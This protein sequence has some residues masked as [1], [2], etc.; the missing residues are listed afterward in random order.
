MNNTPGSQRLRIL[1]EGKSHTSSLRGKQKRQ[2]KVA[3]KNNRLKAGHIT[4][5]LFSRIRTI[6][7][8]KGHKL[9]HLLCYSDYVLRI[10]PRKP[11]S[12]PTQILINA[13]RWLKCAHTK[14]KSIMKPN[15]L[16]TNDKTPSAG[17]EILEKW[18]EVEI[19][20]GDRLIT[21]AELKR[22][23]KDKDAVLCQAIDK[24]DKAI[25]GAAKKL[26]VIAT[27]TAGYDNV[28]IVEATRRG[29]YVTYSPVESG[30]TETT[31]DFT[32]A[33]LMAL[34]RRIPEAHKLVT[35]GKW[36]GWSPTL[37]MGVEIRRKVLGIVGLGRI[38]NTIARTAKCFD[39]KVIYFDIMRQTPE[40]EKELGITYQPI[41]ALLKQSDFVCLH[42]PLLKETLQ[43]ISEDRLKMMK[44]TAFLINASRGPVVDEKALIKA[45]REKWIAGAALDVYE[46]EPAE[47]TNPLLK[48]DNTILT[49][50]IG[51][52]AKETRER[53]AKCTA[54]Y[55][56]E[57]LKGE[58]PIYLANPEVMKVRPLSEVKMI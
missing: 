2:S 40:R 45:L 27:A 22:R 26:K 43:L 33:L 56:I 49:P 38:G 24:F 9:R 25:V 21:R 31:A 53:M 10:F 17:I 51:G 32:W 39:M 28:D 58:K 47:K 1:T 15:V 54:R 3:V 48:M 13:I 44:P 57:V 42:V 37:C 41:D 12:S 4:M 50:H 11:F 6:L 36:K 35:S 34:A 46:K 16:V 18:C 19:Y 52:A 30:V 55:L 23:I 8:S 20:K 7:F 29:I 5:F 14:G